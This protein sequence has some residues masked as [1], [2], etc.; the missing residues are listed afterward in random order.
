MP[1]KFEFI[2]RRKGEQM[3]LAFEGSPPG[4]HLAEEPWQGAWLLPFWCLS[5]R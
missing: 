1:A 3:W 2:V 5:Y 4:A